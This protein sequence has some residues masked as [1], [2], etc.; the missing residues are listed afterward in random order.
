MGASGLF[1]PKSEEKGY[2][3]LA[4]AN[5]PAKLSETGIFIQLAKAV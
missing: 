4:A 1:K 5:F 3:F 2:V